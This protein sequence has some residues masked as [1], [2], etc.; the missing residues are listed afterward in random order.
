MKT[1]KFCLG[2]KFRIMEKETELKKIIRE[3]FKKLKEKFYQ[4]YKIAERETDTYP[5]ILTQRDIIESLPPSLQIIELIGPE[6]HPNLKNGKG[7]ILNYNFDELNSNKVQYCGSVP[8]TQPEKLVSILVD[9][10]HLK[11]DTVKSYAFDIC[12]NFQI[13][14]MW[15]PPETWYLQ[16]IPDDVMKNPKALDDSLRHTFLLFPDVPILSDKFRRPF[17]DDYVRTYNLQPDPIFQKD[18]FVKAD[19]RSSTFNLSLEKLQKNVANI[20]L[21]PSVPEDVKI[22][23]KRAKQLYLFGYFR[24]EFFTISQHYA[25]LAL[26]SAMKTRYAKSLGDKAILTDRKDKDLRREISV[27]TYRAIGGFCRANKGW[28]VRTLLVNNESFPYSGRKLLDWLENNHMIRRWERGSY[29]ARLFLRHS[30]SHQERPSLMMPDSSTLERV[31][32][33]IN[34]LFHMAQKTP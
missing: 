25:F 11:E 23:F 19:R 24:Y 9:K 34:Y 21:I 22:V 16:F 27:T 30:Y 15:D 17:H 6:N 1:S 20:Q 5:P 33:Q 4:K 31:A 18:E 13:T 14:G 3:A 10:C 26:E 8:H 7:Y 29:E 2:E 32:E 12:K 28:N